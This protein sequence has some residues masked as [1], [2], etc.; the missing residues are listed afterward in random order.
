MDRNPL[1]LK[2]RI[3]ESPP[4]FPDPL[5]NPYSISYPPDVT[6][7]KYELFSFAFASATCCS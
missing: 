1:L 3:R 6:E 2:K 7:I 5:I 4:P